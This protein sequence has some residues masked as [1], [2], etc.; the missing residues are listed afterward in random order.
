MHFER[1]SFPA[2]CGKLP[3]LKPPPPLPSPRPIAADIARPYPLAARIRLRT[4]MSTSNATLATKLLPSSTRNSR[5]NSVQCPLRCSTPT[6]ML[7]GV[8]LLARVV[9]S[10]IA[11]GCVCQLCASESHRSLCE[12]RVRARHRRC[13]CEV[14]HLEDVPRSKSRSK[15]I[16]IEFCAHQD[17]VLSAFRR[18]KGVFGECQIEAYI[19]RE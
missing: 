1:C 15:K 19:G 18:S 12:L 16:A 14:H 13:R 4:L 11:A 2:F 17:S 7:S 10:F 5:R 6:S 8:C 9:I 3:K